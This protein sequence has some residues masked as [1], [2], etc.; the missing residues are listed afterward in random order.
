MSQPV[1]SIPFHEKSLVAIGAST[2]L[3]L[4]VGVTC[5]ALN[6]NPNVTSAL[7]A[8]VAAVPA[9]VAYNLQRRRSATAAAT[10]GA[11]PGSQ[12]DPAGRSVALIVVLYASALLLVDSV[13]GAISFSLAFSASTL[14]AYQTILLVF[15]AISLAACGFVT[16]AFV[17]RFGAHP[18]R[19]TAIGTGVTFVARAVIVLLSGLGALLLEVF[20]SAIFML[21]VNLLAAF[22]VTRR[23]ANRVAAPAVVA[24]VPVA[25]AVAPE[26]A[27]A[28]RARQPRARQP[29]AGRC[30]PRRR[31]ARPDAIRGLVP[32]PRAPRHRTLVGWSGLD[33]PSTQHPV[34][35]AKRRATAVRSRCVTSPSR[36]PIVFRHEPC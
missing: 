28:P 18:Y 4:I 8:G 21:G 14:A 12:A 22:I 3:A 5:S 24:G 33:R 31:A 30:G 17:P 36:G 10:G 25:P 9:A 27:V 2:A 29:R 16:V 19:W 6:A 32:R 20:L 34:S 15:A 1:P 23:R 35:D 13:I 26:P 7:T 11:A